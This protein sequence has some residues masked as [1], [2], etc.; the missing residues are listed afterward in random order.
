MSEG[1]LN[2]NLVGSDSK[3]VQ[4]T[5][6]VVV[7]TAIILA[8]DKAFQKIVKGPIEKGAIAAVRMSG[9][10]VAESSKTL[11]SPSLLRRLS[12]RSAQKAGKLTMSFLKNLPEHEIAWLVKSGKAARSA[13]K[14]GQSVEEATKTGLKAFDK[15]GTET[16]TKVGEDLASKASTKIAEEAAIKTS[17][18][19]GEV[20]AEEVVG[21]LTFFATF[22]AATGAET[23]GI[24]CAVGAAIT[25]IML[26]FD[27]I[28]LLM[29][30]LDPTGISNFV[31][32]EDIKAVA[33]ATSQATNSNYP[34]IGNYLDQ[35]VY[36]EPVD[37]IFTQ[38][39]NNSVVMDPKWGP[40]YNQLMDD[41]M[42][43]IGIIG[44]WRSRVT[45][46]ETL[47]DGNAP[48]II[49]ADTQLYDKLITSSMQQMTQPSSQNSSSPNPAPAPS[50]SPTPS[51]K[52]QT[53][54]VL[55]IGIFLVIA[56]LAIFFFISV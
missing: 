43:S 8:A 45:N 55:Y 49:T 12:L 21:Q 30:L 27:V 19:A 13:M 38:D 6:K 50:P 39:A 34:L 18:K 51:P 22:C 14:A 48:A 20:M 4:I 10:V 31:T 23:A 29:D 15:A 24:G 11:V 32:L 35:E 41:Y 56:F 17:V 40:I 36:F 1:G 2:T 7:D 26:A 25:V 5:Q 46:I 44:D 33:D 53:N 3:E 52:T 28:N 9:K 47:L 16:A 37:F 54:W 42:K